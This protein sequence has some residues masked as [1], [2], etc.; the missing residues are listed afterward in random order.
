MGLTQ[1]GWATS[2]R[3]GGGWAATCSEAK[4]SIAPSTTV[5][6]V[7]AGQAVGGQDKRREGTGRAAHASATPLCPSEPRR[8]QRGGTRGRVASQSEGRA[9]RNGRQWWWSRAGVC[10]STSAAAR[11]RCRH[12]PPPGQL[13]CP[14]CEAGQNRLGDDFGVVWGRSGGDQEVRLAGRRGSGVGAGG[15]SERRKKR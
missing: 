14:G 4:Q 8:P 6:G 10:G 11:R 12:S 13:S 7:R 1:L 5:S 9:R 15:S 3:S 2:A